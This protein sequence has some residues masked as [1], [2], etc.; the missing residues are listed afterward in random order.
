MDPAQAPGLIATTLMARL[1]A[2][3]LFPQW[4]RDKVLERHAQGL[5]APA[6]AAE[7]APLDPKERTVRY[8]IAAFS[9]TQM[10]TR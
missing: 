3:T 9:R 7:L 8:I 4:I 2:G 1:P 6:I 5:N 10:G